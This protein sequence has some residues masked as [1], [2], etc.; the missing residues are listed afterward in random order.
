[1]R[2]LDMETAA[3]HRDRLYA[4][5][6]DEEDARVCKDIPDSACSAVPKNFFLILLTQWLTKLAD[7]LANAKTVLPWLLNASGAP[8]GLIALLVPIRESGSLIPQLLIGGWVR[9][10]AVRKYFYVAGCVAQGVL[11]ALILASGM[12]LEGLQAGIAII[13]CL[14]LFSL[15]RG[16]C[17]VASKDVIGKTVPKTRRGRLTGL[18]ASIA[19]L[20]TIGIAIA[21]SSGLMQSANYFVP[22]LCLASLAWLVAAVLFSRVAEE[23]GA[24]EGGGNALKEALSKFALLKTDPALRNF[25]VMRACLMSSGLAAPFL[26]TMSLSS[27]TEASA[28]QLGMFVGL[29]GLAGLLSGHVWGKWSDNNS[30]WVM[31]I[32]GGV[33]GLTCVAAVSGLISNAS[34]VDVLAMGLF[35]VLMVAHEG[36]R[37]GRKT[38]LVDMASG[39]K[40]TDYV[41]L[42]NTL[43]GL[44]L[45]LVGIL[46]GVLAQVSLVAVMTF[47]AMS[48]FAAVILGLLERKR[49][50]V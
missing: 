28:Q 36:V 30:L 18:S 37:V 49:E 14:V 16:L 32:A 5:L 15:A 43:I 50:T 8:A 19:G 6:V 4:F 25:V 44:L 39:N 33:C 22:L 31:I 1:M 12:M 7:A 27:G 42:S 10:F 47:F 20:L 24:T 2:T 9:R 45:L 40:R 11:M 21:M 29:S 48:C 26:V 46:T 34:Y 41:A 38:Y 3:E 23:H 35:F 13:A 17:S